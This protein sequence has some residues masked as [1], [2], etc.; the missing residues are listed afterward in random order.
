MGRLTQAQL[1][2]LIFT[3]VVML[4]AA[5]VL[6]YLAFREEPAAA[7]L[8]SPAPAAETAR[9]EAPG[10]A[11]EAV[12][13]AVF[14]TQLEADGRFTLTQEAPG[15]YVLTMEE[16]GFTALLEI[17][18]ADGRVGSLTWFFAPEAPALESP[19]NALERRVAE[20]REKSLAARG[21][22]ITAILL[23]CMEAADLNGVLQRPVLRLW[24]DAALETGQSGKTYRASAGDCGFIAY[25]SETDG[26]LVCAFLPPA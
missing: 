13:P 6:V 14:L 19:E 23:F 10:A 7:E 16:S 25:V 18:E 5:G 17:G 8:S 2:N 1:Q 20:A 3:G 9:A 21:D 15:L 24:C 11:F 26:A 4:V 22:S 12:P